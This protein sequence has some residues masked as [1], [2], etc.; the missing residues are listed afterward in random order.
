ME[1]GLNSGK[2]QLLS[3]ELI[4][5]HADKVKEIDDLCKALWRGLGWHYLLDLIWI[6]DNIERAELPAGATIVDAGGGQGMLQYLLAERGYNVVSV[7]YTPRGIPR[8]YARLFDFELMG[9]LDEVGRDEYSQHITSMNKLGAK[10]K[11]LP[12]RIRHRKFSPIRTVSMAARRMLGWRKPGRIQIYHADMMDMRALP[13][14][15]VDAVVSVSAIEHM[16]KQDIPKAVAEFE[17]ISKKGGFMALTLSAARDEDWY[18]ENA[19]GWCF[20]AASLQDLFGMKT[21]DIFG[22]QDYDLVMAELQASQELEKRLASLYFIS[23][24]NGMPWGIWDPKYVPVG[25]LKTGLE[26]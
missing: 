17:R 25:I 22:P 18:S 8:L 5:T 26:S 16:H 4:Q 6:L 3:V 9:D 14:G 2:L 10:L 19:K 20:T 12:H 1:F 21:N 11:Q 15:S 23:G 13:D 7:D 24:T